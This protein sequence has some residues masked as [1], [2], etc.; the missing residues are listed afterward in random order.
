M[1]KR[2]H[3]IF[4]QYIY[5]SEF[6]HNEAKYVLQT[7]IQLAV[8]SCN[9]ADKWTS[10]HHHVLLELSVIAQDEDHFNFHIRNNISSILI[11]DFYE[12]SQQGP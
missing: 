2:K 9:P 5:F 3:N 7:A 8:K 12:T 11:S 6:L 10:P 4:K 1:F